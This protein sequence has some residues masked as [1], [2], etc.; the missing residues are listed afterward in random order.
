MFLVRGVFLIEP[1]RSQNPLGEGTQNVIAEE[2]PSTRNP[3]VSSTDFYRSWEAV[4]V[5]RNILHSTCSYK[6]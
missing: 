5:R 1:N 2:L 4:V 3:R 6:R